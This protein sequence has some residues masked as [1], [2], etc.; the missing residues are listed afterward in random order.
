MNIVLVGPGRAGH[1]LRDRAIAYG[2]AARLVRDPAGAAGADVVLLTVPDRAIAGV[3]DGLPADQWIGHVSGATP[4]AALGP[5]ARRFVLHPAQ[6]LERDGGAAQ[7][8]GVS[9]FTTGADDQAAGF[10]AAL[11]EALGLRAVPL[12]EAVRPLPHVACVFAS[13]YLVTL[14]ATACRLL[15]VDDAPRIL[16]P[17]ARRALENAIAQGDAMRPT[18]P[19]SRG[20][21]PT[22]A[23]HLAALRRLEPTVTDLYVALARATLPLVD[24]AAARRVEALL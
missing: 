17:L 14:L 1:A 21:E 7:L 24:A 16:A 19:V 8:D 13:N 10:A 15:D 18:G 22:V 9:A 6:S 2:H 3:A 11:A 23:A 5:S 12:S 4:L 20:D